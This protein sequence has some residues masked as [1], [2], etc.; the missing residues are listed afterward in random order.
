MMT[1]GLIGEHLPHSF[2]KEIH[3][4]CAPYEYELCELERSAVKDFMERAEFSA[5]NVTIPYKQ[6]VMPYLYEIHRQARAIGAVNTVVK[7]DGRLY[8]YNTDFYGMLALVRRIGVE[9]LG[10]KVL[11]LGTGGTAHT[12]R[13]VIRSEGARELLSVGRRAEPEKN[14]IS[15]EEA[16]EKHTDAEVIFNTTPCGMFPYADGGPNIVGTP[17]DISRFPRLCGVVDAVYNP[18]RTNLVVDAKE[19]GI[20]AEGGL[21]MLV[22]QA[23]VASRVFLGEQ[24]ERAADDP[25]TVKM[26]DKV[27]FDIVKQKENIVLTGMPGS[28]KSTVGRALAKKLGRPFIDT[29][30]LI[31]EKTGKAI[32]D[33]FADVG[34]KGFR[35]I[36]SEAVKEAANRS[37]GCVIATGGGAILRDDNLRALKRSG[38]IYFLNRSLEK[39]LPSTDRPLAATA[40]AI[41]KRY[42]ER[43]GRYIATADREIVTDEVIE[44]TIS[45][46]SEDFYK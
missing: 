28:G 7:R 13:A 43:Y 27:Y 33:I 21:Y 10:K 25:E 37:V 35:E 4:L 40:E 5:I 6:T 44:H 36:E 19:R 38:R 39:L 14:I 31:V 2:S 45:A 24:I 15:Y 30:M 20:S 3:A 41:K 26:I 8:G 46:I 34:E 18:I 16:Y 29:D 1:Y 17:I 23:V 12:A 11:V 22:G 42:E 32:S 9:L